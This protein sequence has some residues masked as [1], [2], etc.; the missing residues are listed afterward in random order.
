M[1]R[2]PRQRAIHWPTGKAAHYVAAKSDEIVD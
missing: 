2:V 1:D